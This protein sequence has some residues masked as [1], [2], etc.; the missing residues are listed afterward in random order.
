MLVEPDDRNLSTTQSL[1][2]QRGSGCHRTSQSQ[3]S[4]SPDLFFMALMDSY[5]TH[6][7]N[8]Y[9]T[10]CMYSFDCLRCAAKI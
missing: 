9:N 2:Q 8:Q 7:W 4:L 6:R 5:A 1:G 10:C 3:V